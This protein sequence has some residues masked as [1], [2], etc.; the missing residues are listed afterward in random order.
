MQN[1]CLYNE[2]F[3]D[4]YG[5]L[6]IDDEIAEGHARMWLNKSLNHELELRGIEKHSDFQMWHNFVNIEQEF[7]YSLT[8]LGFLNFEYAEPVK[9]TPT[10]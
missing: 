2:D 9:F 4:A 3:I 7:G 5:R 6:Y 8:A 1:Y 10:K